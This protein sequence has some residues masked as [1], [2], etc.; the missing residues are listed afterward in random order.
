MFTG[1]PST[2][3]SRNCGSSSRAPERSD[4]HIRS[5]INN[6]QWRNKHDTARTHSI[7]HIRLL[8]G[9]VKT[10]VPCSV[11]NVVKMKTAVCFNSPP[12]SPSQ[13][14]SLPLCIYYYFLCPTHMNR[15]LN[16]VYPLL[17]LLI[18]V[19]TSRKGLS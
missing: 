17:P 19:Y 16:L 14:F 9:A 18:F 11:E 13:S 3:L 8:L 4:K 10:N 1:G 6:K 5:D 2:D 7:T 12:R 15:Q